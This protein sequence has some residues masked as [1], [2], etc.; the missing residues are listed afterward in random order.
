MR[1][2]TSWMVA[3]E[4]KL[5]V[6]PLLNVAFASVTLTLLAVASPASAADIHSFVACLKGINSTN[7]ADAVAC[8]PAG[9]YAT[10]TLS[11]ESAQPACTLRDGTRLPRVI[12]SCPGSGGSQT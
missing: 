2:K 10:V 9:C 3:S 12:L 4:K 8:V 5:F 6:K 1:G 11:E 7:V